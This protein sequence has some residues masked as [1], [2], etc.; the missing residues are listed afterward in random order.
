M[1]L[2]DLFTGNIPGNPLANIPLGDA[3]DPAMNRFTFNVIGGSLRPGPG[4]NTGMP[5]IEAWMQPP[6]PA[7]APKPAMPVDMAAMGPSNYAPQ[8]KPSY[9]GQGPASMGHRSFLGHAPQN[10]QTFNPFGFETQTPF[11][12]GLRSRMTNWKMG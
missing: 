3:S 10:P 12:G 11:T 2:R 5:G 8:A 9:M 4:V 1:N 7:P 6:T